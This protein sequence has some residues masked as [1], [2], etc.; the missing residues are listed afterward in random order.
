MIERLFDTGRIHGRAL[1][2][3]CVVL[4]PFLRF[5]LRNRY[6]MWSAE[7]LAAALVLILVCVALAALARSRMV[8]LG[9]VAAC[10]VLMATVPVVRLLAGRV[11]LTP[12]QSALALAV[13]LAA[14]VALMRQRFAL[15]VAVFTLS[16][17]AVDLGLAARERFATHAEAQARSGDAPAHV[18]YLVFDEHIGIAGFP[19]DIP[20]C[21]EARSAIEAGFRKWR[22]RLYPN[23]YSNYPST[24]SSLSSLLNRRLLDRR[25]VLLNEDSQE[26]R[27]GTRTLRDNK[28]LRSYRDRGYRIEVV[29]HR[30]INHVPAGLRADELHEYWDELGVLDRAP[31]PWFTRFRWLVGNYQQSD[32]VLS[33]ARAFFPFRFA[34]H[35]TGPLS[36]SAVWPRRLAEEIVEER[37][38]TFFLAHLIAPHFPYLYRKN[39]TVRDL[40]EW[41][42]DRVDQRSNAEMYRDRYWRYCEQAQFL[43]RQ[44]DALLDALR[45]AGVFDSTLIVV[46]GDHGSRIRRVL[47][48]AGDA[49]RPTG[50]DPER[51]DY[52]GPPSV[53]DMLDRFSALLAVKRPSARE[54]SADGRQGSMLRFL[55]EELPIGEGPLPAA[56]DSVYLFDGAGKPSEIRILDYWRNEETGGRKWRSDD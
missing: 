29:Q 14:M 52:S 13:G 25:R 27:W 18:L 40:R 33:K 56:V 31:G 11:E 50:S 47:K 20:A 43:S 5:L 32:L 55:S 30:A 35:T 21:V 19:P 12:Q 37:R 41:S 8:F 38:N 34:P 15:L 45:G 49:A 46:H 48:G 17:F 39:G 16:A 3:A 36:A 2:L 26:W 6:R 1:V 23:A 24:T 44:L 10:S 42:G 28:L 53:R 9:V 54:A 4:L 22:F 51:F 7:A